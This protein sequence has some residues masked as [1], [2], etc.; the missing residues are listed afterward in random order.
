MELHGAAG[1]EHPAGDVRVGRALGEERGHC[2]LGVGKGSPAEPGALPT[3]VDTA[4]YPASPQ[5]GIGPG[6][7]P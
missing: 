6:R 2:L 1:N 7:I 3:A 5:P 4:P